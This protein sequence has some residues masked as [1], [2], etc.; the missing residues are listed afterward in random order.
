MAHRF[1]KKRDGRLLTTKIGA[2]TGDVYLNRGALDK[3]SKKREP[4]VYAVWNDLY[5][6]QVPAHFIGEAWQA[7]RDN[8]QHTFII[9]TKRPKR[10][11]LLARYHKLTMLPNVWFLA[12]TENQACL[13]ERAP[14]VLD[15]PAAAV[16]GIIIEPMLEYV[17]VDDYLPSWDMSEDVSIPGLDWVIVGCET[18]PQRRRC[19]IANIREV[20]RHCRSNVP[21]WVKAV[22]IDGR[23]VKKTSELPEDVRFRELPKGGDA[24]GHG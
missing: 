18:G 24:Y 3:P 6:P 17:G 2:W 9:I 23:I 20:V 13:D 12:T 14:W 21:V 15:F 4:I 22:N 7:M 1:Q 5:H 19:D 8:P 10:A 16:K 11:T